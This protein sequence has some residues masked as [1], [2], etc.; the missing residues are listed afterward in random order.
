ME[1]KESHGAK[2]L[3]GTSDSQLRIKKL[4]LYY[5][6]MG[7]CMYTGENIELD[8]LMNDNLY[9]IDHIYPRHFVKDDNIG[10]NLVL[11]KKEKNA[12]KSDSF[13][14]ENEIRTKM[15]PYWKN[16]A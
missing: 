4:Y 3:S 9:D 13:P 1:K 11:V 2:E 16:V 6:Q 5:L 15:M 8:Q 14:I 12:H 10:N 7:K